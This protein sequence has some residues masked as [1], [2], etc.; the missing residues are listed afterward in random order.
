MKN[1]EGKMGKYVP[2]CIGRRIW[3]KFWAFQ[4]G[5]GKSYADTDTIPE[6]APSTEREGEVVLRWPPI[7]KGKAGLPPKVV[8]W[9]HLSSKK[10]DLVILTPSPENSQTIFNLDTQWSTWGVHLDHSLPCLPN[11]EE[12]MAKCIPSS[13]ILQC[14]SYFQTGSIEMNSFTYAS[15]EERKTFFD[16]IQP[17]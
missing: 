5:G 3:E 16:T 8:T 1:Y 10:I 14:L 7:P 15:L 9:S 11:I 17:F 13:N 6:T 2:L 4:Q 12:F